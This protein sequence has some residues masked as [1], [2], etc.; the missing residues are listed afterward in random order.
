MDTVTRTRATT[1]MK[2][3]HTSAA[4][5]AI[6]LFCAHHAAADP[7]G[8]FNSG[9][10]T[11][12]TIASEA[13]LQSLVDAVLGTGL[14][15]DVD[16]SGAGVWSATDWSSGL[17][18]SLAFEY[19]GNNAINTFGIWSGTD[20][21]TLHHVPVFFG[22]ATGVGS[23]AETAATITWDEAGTAM[24]IAG[25][26]ALV[27][28]GVFSDVSPL[29]FGFYLQAGSGSIFYTA[30]AL[31]GGGAARAVAFQQDGTPLWAIAFEDWNDGD[32]NDGVLKVQSAS[33]AGTSISAVPEPG[34]LL[35]LGGGLAGVLARRRTRG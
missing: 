9:P 4:F 10:A 30:D 8:P 35:L 33:A 26:C 15:V 17:L 31:N 5:L 2:S 19:A 24:T 1:F 25:D 28:C 3:T 27:N 18:A 21:A 14:D 6:S 34:I 29:W 16:Q 23:G 13:D 22:A 20:S 7:I 12:N 11:I 32:F